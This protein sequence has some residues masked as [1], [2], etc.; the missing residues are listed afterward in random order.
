VPARLDSDKSKYTDY[1]AWALQAVAGQQDG[2]VGSLVHGVVANNAWKAEIEKALR[3]CS[4]RTRTR[5]KFAGAVA[6]AYAANK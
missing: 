4:C 3:R 2:V 1:L 5:T 6:T